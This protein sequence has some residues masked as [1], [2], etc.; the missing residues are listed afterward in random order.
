MH[1]AIT[2]NTGLSGKECANRFSIPKDLV[3]LY[4]T[5]THK[6]VEHFRIELE[7]GI[8]CMFPMT[9]IGP[10]PISYYPSKE[11]EEIIAYIENHFK[12]R[13]NVVIA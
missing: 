11:D 8:V 6:G 9:D 12:K 4:H 7:H 10:T 3:D 5:K 1:P 13:F 2:F